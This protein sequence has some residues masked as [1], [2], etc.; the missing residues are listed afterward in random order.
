MATAV[1]VES[2]IR[3]TTDFCIDGG[4]H[5]AIVGSGR[6][7]AFRV[8]L[9]VRALQSIIGY[10]VPI[11]GCSVLPFS[12]SIEDR[13]VHALKSFDI[14]KHVDVTNKTRE[15]ATDVKIRI[16]GG[17]FV[18]TIKKKVV[19]NTQIHYLSYAYQYS[20]LEQHLPM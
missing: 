13:L 9:A 5:G 3:V 18:V 15:F 7:D 19:Q 1:A 4:T 17:Y 10:K 2:L 8:T 6:E 20:I 11:P 12:S 16:Q 14:T